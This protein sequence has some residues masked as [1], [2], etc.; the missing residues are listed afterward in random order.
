LATKAS[1]HFARLRLAFGV[2]FVCR[3]KIS[4]MSPEF[5]SLKSCSRQSLTVIGLVLSLGVMYSRASAGSIV[6]IGEFSGAVGAAVSAELAVGGLEAALAG[7]GDEFLMEPM[8]V[9]AH[10]I[11][12]TVGAVP[13]SI[14]SGAKKRKCPIKSME[15]KR[16][17]WCLY[18]VG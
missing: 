7:E 11:Q 5:T 2:N 1:S 16:L 10:T 15:T 6:P 14:V 3:C 13:A 12:F 17:T 9:G 8:A 4:R 18:G